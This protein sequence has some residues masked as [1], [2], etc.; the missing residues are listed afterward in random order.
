MTVEEAE[1]AKLPP[2][3]RFALAEWIEQNEDI[4]DLRRAAL[5]REIRIGLDEI[6]Q[7][8]C[9]EC[10][11]EAELSAFFAGVKARGRDVAQPSRLL[12]EKSGK[13]PDRPTDKMSVPRHTACHSQIELNLAPFG[14]V[15]ESRPFHSAHAHKRH[16]YR[17]EFF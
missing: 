15:L 5:I 10:K 13:M 16:G 17:P 2:N 7:G 3:D 11:D 14:S 6:D 1:V 4:R 8:E 9:V 12:P